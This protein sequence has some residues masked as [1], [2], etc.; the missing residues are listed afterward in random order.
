MRDLKRLLTGTVLA[1]SAIGGWLHQPA[2]LLA[3]A[4]VSL[5]FLLLEDR[6][7]RGQIGAAAWASEGYARFLVGTNLSLLLRNAI[8]NAAILAIASA[9]HSAL[10]G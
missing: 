10:G 4:A 8:L 7:V 2:W 6:A 9:L 3:P 5:L 1:G